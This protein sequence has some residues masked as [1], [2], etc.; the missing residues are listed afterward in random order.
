MVSREKQVIPAQPYQIAAFFYI[1]AVTGVSSSADGETLVSLSRWGDVGVLLSFEDVYAP[2][3]FKSHSP[4]IRHQAVGA[5]TA[6]LC[7]IAS[8]AFH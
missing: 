6:C 2:C 7:C 8:S 1:C 5:L 4:S 3:R